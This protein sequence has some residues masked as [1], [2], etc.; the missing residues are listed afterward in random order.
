VEREI[1]ELFERES[2]F[3]SAAYFTLLHED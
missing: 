2:L 1:V 3:T